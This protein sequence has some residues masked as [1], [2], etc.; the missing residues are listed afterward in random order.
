MHCDRREPEDWDMLSALKRVWDL[1][2]TYRSETTA[3]KAAWRSKTIWANALAL[4]AALL[5]RYG[6]VELSSEDGLALLAVVNLVLRLI[7]R[8]PVG[9]YQDKS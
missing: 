4:L 8:E 5:S 2:V 7:S 1:L 9:F 6:G 3:G